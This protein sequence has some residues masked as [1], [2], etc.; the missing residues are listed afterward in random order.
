M[1]EAQILSSSFLLL[2][3]SP[4]AQGRDFSSFPPF[5]RVCARISFQGG[6]AEPR[7]A[8]TLP[9]KIIFPTPFAARGFELFHPHPK[10]RFFGATGA[11]SDG[12][13]EKYS[14][15]G[16]KKNPVYPNLKE[17]PS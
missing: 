5:I 6:E 1:K 11:V 12:T 15:R 3:L 13:W 8:E 2:C 17:N 7:D 16:K 4:N 9:L 10:P 14:G